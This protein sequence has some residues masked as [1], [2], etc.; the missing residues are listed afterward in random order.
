[1]ILKRKKIEY[2]NLIFIL[3]IQFYLTTCAMGE[4]IVN[5]SF[6]FDTLIDSFEETEISVWG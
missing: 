2:S 3:I 5:H 4:T 6:S 1:M